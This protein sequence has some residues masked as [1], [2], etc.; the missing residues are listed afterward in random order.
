MWFAIF[1]TYIY[2]IFIILLHGQ[3][4]KTTYCVCIL[5]TKESS[6]LKVDVITKLYSYISMI[7][8]YLYSLYNTCLP[9]TGKSLFG[10]H[11]TALNWLVFILGSLACRALANLHLGPTRLPCAAKSSYVCHLT[12]MKARHCLILSNK[13]A[14]II[15]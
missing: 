2:K 10:F 6:T 14:K 7:F 1:I 4:S 5:S 3:N 15:R 9:C 12:W 11:K 8:K 13:L